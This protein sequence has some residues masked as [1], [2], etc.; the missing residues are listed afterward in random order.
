MG[1]G[2]S[3]GGSIG[4]PARRARSALACRG[5]P[6]VTD[7]AIDGCCDPGSGL[8]RYDLNDAAL[9][10]PA[11]GFAELWHG[12]RPSAGDL[13]PGRAAAAA[14]VLEGLVAAGRAETDGAHLV[15][16]H[17]LTLGSSRHRIEH[18]GRDHHTWCAFDAIGI[19]AALGLDAT[20]HTDCP[21]C[22]RLLAVPIL[23]GDPGGAP[24]LVLWL[25]TAPCSHLR[26]EFCAS[27]DLYCSIQHL[28]A[29]IDQN[30]V[31]GTVTSLSDAAS[32]GRE[33]WADVVH[34]ELDD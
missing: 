23:R 4:V 15:G 18:A 13:L 26:D 32:L 7:P 17:G 8:L 12:F 24:G 2:V 5:A 25:P 22:E 16:V 28:D 10:L 31:A 21:T 27:A 33:T 3:A 14:Q 20:A 6:S 11:A 34:L 30:A 19:P 29:N 1:S 9:E